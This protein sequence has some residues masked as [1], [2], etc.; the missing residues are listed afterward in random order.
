MAEINESQNFL[1]SVPFCKKQSYKKQL[2][3]MA[4][5]KKRQLVEIDM[6]KKRFLILS[7][8]N[9]DKTNINFYNEICNARCQESN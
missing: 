6:V 2:V 1:H 3:D 8:R 4:M 7:S 9:F 5:V